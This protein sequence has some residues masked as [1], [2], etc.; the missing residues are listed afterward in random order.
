MIYPN[1]RRPQ[2]AVLWHA[3]AALPGFLP[4]IPYTY[5]PLIMSDIWLQCCVHSTQAATLPLHMAFPDIGFTPTRCSP[6]QGC[7]CQC[8]CQEAQQ[9]EEEN[10]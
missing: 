7:C 9:A 1:P 5:K 8:S 2:Q 10:G 3:A 4:L 6:L